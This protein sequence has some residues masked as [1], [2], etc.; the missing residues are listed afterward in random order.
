[1]STVHASPGYARIARADR[2][3]CAIYE[4]HAK[5]INIFSL[6]VCGLESNMVQYGMPKVQRS[7]PTVGLFVIPGN[8]M[9]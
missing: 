7:R 8:K 5:R 3:N 4:K 2:C 9:R 1:M 6:K